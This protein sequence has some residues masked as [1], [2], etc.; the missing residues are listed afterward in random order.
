MKKI[1][2]IIIACIL[3]TLVG[4]AG[5]SGHEGEAK[6]PSG[7]SVQEGRDYQEVVDEFKEKGFN[8]I[9]TEKL[10]DL[11]TGWLTKDGEVES[12]S[13]DGDKDYSPDVWYS[14]DVEVVITYHTFPEKEKSDKESSEEE[15]SEEEQSTNDTTEEDE[16]S[17]N[18]TTEEDEQSTNDKTEESNEEILTVEN[19]KDLAALLAVKNEND[20]TVG[21]FAKK[22]AGRT[23][24]FD[25]NIAH[26]MPHGS[27]KTRYDILIFAGDYSE[28]TFS[29]PN[30]KFE[31][32]NIINDLNLTG[33]NIPD[34][35]GM[36]Q[37]LH[38][39]AV[40]EEYDENSGLFFLE[41][42]STE[43]R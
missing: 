35:I 41:P 2:G 17:A 12:V 20:P 7:S 33:S 25:G 27:Y 1:I 19:N 22:Y 4:C 5:D 24:E 9:K 43:I 26:M 23:I 39:T 8:N 32:V 13:V 6:T 42:I 30:F 3:I 31:D 21:E 28:T 15:S 10:E 38:I 14:N 34:T 11:I 40:V 18:D 36:G 16:Q 29:G 37:N